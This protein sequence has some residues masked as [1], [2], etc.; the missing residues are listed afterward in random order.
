MMRITQHREGNPGSGLDYY[1]RITDGS[2][3]ISLYDAAGN[4]VGD[5][6]ITID[7]DTTTLTG[8]ATALGGLTIGGED[9]LNS[10]VINGSLNIEIDSS[11]HSGYT[12]PFQRTAVISLQPLA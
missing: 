8:L 12:L 7:A 6:T 10:T 9:A 4:F 3:R 2:F 5:S 1:D 11:T